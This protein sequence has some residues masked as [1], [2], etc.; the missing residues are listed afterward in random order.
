MRGKDRR[1]LLCFR[2]MGRGPML[3]HSLSF[4]RIF[5]SEA[6]RNDPLAPHPPNPEGS[7]TI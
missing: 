7:A 5:Q 2:R 6:D 4:S 1:V 3:A